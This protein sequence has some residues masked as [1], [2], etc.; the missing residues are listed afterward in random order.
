MNKKLLAELFPCLPCLNEEPEGNVFN[1]QRFTVHDGPGIRTEI[2]LKGCPLRCKWCGNPESFKLNSEVGV[3]ENRCIGIANCGLCIKACPKADQNIFTIKD[4]K[5][6]NIDREICDNCLKCSD[7]CYPSALK[8]WGKTMTVGEVMDIIQSDRSFYD[9]SG[10]GVTISGGEALFQWAF[11]L[12]ILKACK[13]AGIH[14]CVE[15]ALHCK[16][17]I[18]DEILPYTDMIITDIKHMDSE[19][20]KAYTGVGNEQILQNIIKVTKTNKP[21]ILRIPIIPNHNDSLENINETKAFILDELGNRISQVQFLRY[22]RLGEEKY[23]SLG[24]PY[25]M[26]ETDGERGD[27]EEYI[28][29]LVKTMQDDGIPAVAGSSE[30]LKL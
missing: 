11:T 23:Q 26:D 22:R 6:V 10:G 29:T 15:S 19:K 21:V 8:L 28:R 3:F 5:V 17:E 1:I 25:I 16:E 13:K 18:L 9:R 20:H 27:V 14:T 24:M 12:E 2:F 7:V 4:D 30:V